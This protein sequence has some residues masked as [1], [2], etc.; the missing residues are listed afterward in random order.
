MGNYKVSFKWTCA[1]ISRKKSWVRCQTTANRPIIPLCRVFPAYI[2]PIF[3]RHICVY[4]IF[5]QEVLGS[6]RSFEKRFQSKALFC[7]AMII[8]QRWSREKSHYL[9]FMRNECFSYLYIC[10]FIFFG[11]ISS[12][13]SERYFLIEKL[14]FTYLCIENFFR[15]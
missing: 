3:W 9:L 7:E 13:C 1:C 15:V 10:W 11:K 6:H 14:R 12:S 5:K 2:L 8:L 4:Y